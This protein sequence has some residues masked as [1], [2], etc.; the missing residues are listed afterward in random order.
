[1]DWLVPSILDGVFSWIKDTDSDMPRPRLEAAAS[2]LE[3]FEDR[4]H[5]HFAP[6]LAHLI[7][8]AHH[9]TPEFPPPGTALI[10]IDDISHLFPLPFSRGSSKTSS[11]PRTPTPALQLTLLSDLNR[12]ASSCNLAVVITSHV[13]TRVRQPNGALLVAAHGSKDWDDGF[14][15]RLALFRDFPS[16]VN[17][18]DPNLARLRYAGVIKAYG[19]SKLENDSITEI[20]PFTLSSVVPPLLLSSFLIVWTVGRHVANSASD[21]GLEAIDCFSNKVN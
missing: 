5:H 9:Q 8:L 17:T 1:L 11:V 15:S 12:I 7:A 19:V 16:N 13:N 14:S 21:R 10:V 18:V 4:F 6:S 20:V 3:S 2:Q